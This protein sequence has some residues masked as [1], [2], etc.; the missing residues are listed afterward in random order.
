MRY[1][2]AELPKDM[3]YQIYGLSGTVHA[4]NVFH[5]KTSFKVLPFKFI[6]N[7]VN[8]QVI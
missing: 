4:E 2:Q 5:V 1:E 7:V 8:F 6:F 3:L